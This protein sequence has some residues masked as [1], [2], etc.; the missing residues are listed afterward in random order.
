MKQEISISEAE[1]KVMETVWQNPGQTIGEIIEGLSK[2]NWSEST[3]KTL[4]RRLVEKQALKIDSSGT[5]YHYSPLID[6][7]KCK[8][9]ETRNFLNR[10]YNGSLKMLVANLS[11]DSNLTEK[12]TKQLLDIIDKMEGDEPQ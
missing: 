10:I 2:T 4:V 12:E 5:K 7:K 3:I 9:K 8:I 6:E 11:S 1:W